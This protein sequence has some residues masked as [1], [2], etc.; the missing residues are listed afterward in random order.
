MIYIYIYIIFAYIWVIYR[1][2]VRKY[3][4]TMDNMGNYPD[5]G[6]RPGGLMNGWPMVDDG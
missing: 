2:H 3:S 1:A 5:F 6:M 4:G